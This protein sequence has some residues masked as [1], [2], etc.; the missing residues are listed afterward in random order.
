MEYK[1][2][3]VIQNKKWIIKQDWY[4][5]RFDACP[6]YLHAI[7]EGEIKKESRKGKHGHFGSHIGFFED[8][9]ADWY[10]NLNESKKTGSQLIK[11]IKNDSNFV[12]RLIKKWEDDERR[13]QKHFEKNKFKNF[14]KYS[15][16]EILSVYKKTLA[17]YQKCISS[18]SLIDGFVFSFDEYRRKYLSHIPDEY[19][20]LLSIPIKS[21][22]VRK[23]EKE[24][25][26]IALIILKKGMTSKEDFLKNLEVKK[27]IK[28]HQQKYFWLKN[29]YTNATVLKEQF[30]IDRISELVNKREGLLQDKKGKIKKKKIFKKIR[31]FQ[32][33]KNILK[34]LP[35]WGSWQ[36]DRK[37]YSL[38]L[39]H[40]FELLISEIAA[41]KGIQKNVLKYLL[42][43]EIFQ[44][45]RENYKGKSDRYPDCLFFE[46][47]G[48]FEFITGKKGK[49]IFN[50]IFK[51]NISKDVALIKGNTANG[52]FYKGKV[53]IVKSATEVDKVKKGNIL[54]AVMT[55]PDYIFG[56]KK[57]GAIIT[58]EGG[59]TSHAAIVS[60]ELNIPCIIGTKI[61]T[62]VLN[63]GDLVEV[64]A[65]KGVV[66]VLK[67]AN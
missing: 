31:L 57:A 16:S 3:L 47:N 2:K 62:R 49:L 54:V 35:Y 37:Q 61:A 41:R 10:L 25:E 4:L 38:W 48:K 52:G 44:G 30:F 65:N 9:T 43:Q 1:N 58:D 22:F 32:K 5:Q 6:N 27:L 17:L 64:D 23:E 28:K 21:S 46:R 34:S 50:E 18:T 66:K 67:K 12:V 13:F 36:D 45:Y 11:K 40:L 56:I 24:L 15:D 29:N 14:S 53:A 59:I 63:D 19:L 55:R 60:R 33:D 8:N 26:K 7:V 39:T 20:S 51:T 42:P